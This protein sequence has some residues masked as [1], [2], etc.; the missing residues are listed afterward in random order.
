[1]TC[2]EPASDES[3]AQLLTTGMALPRTSLL[4]CELKFSGKS[5][6]YIHEWFYMAEWLELCNFGVGEIVQLVKLV[7][8]PE[9]LSQCLEPTC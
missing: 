5:Y 9:D 1:M 8:K 7:C 2:T 3:H 4:F 6:T